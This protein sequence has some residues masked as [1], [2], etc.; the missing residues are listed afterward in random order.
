MHFCDLVT[1]G[2]LAG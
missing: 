1:F 2:R